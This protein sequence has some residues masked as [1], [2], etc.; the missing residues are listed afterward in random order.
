M[1]R[2]KP[3][4]PNFKLT[5]FDIE[6]LVQPIICPKSQEIQYYETLS[7]ICTFDKNNIN[8][9]VFFSIVDNSFIQTLALQQIQFSL[10][11][12]PHQRHSFNI[13]LSCLADEHFVQKLLSF[14]GAKFA[15][16]ISELD[17]Y[18]ESKEIHHNL[19]QLQANNIEIWLDDYHSNNKLANMSL[20][21]IFWDRIKI[22]KSFLKYADLESIQALEYFLA[23]F[24]SRGLIFEGVE[25]TQ[26]HQMLKECHSLVQGYHYSR[27][28]PLK[29]EQAVSLCS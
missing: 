9:D 10:A 4:L 1:Q 22:D 12:Y 3:Y 18:T 25:D 15:L 14:N 16:E 29:S 6:T 21:T 28:Y 27:P 11:Q 7:K 8:N 19:S 17:C 13:K 26:H 23:P 2:N 20:D 24:C 5:D